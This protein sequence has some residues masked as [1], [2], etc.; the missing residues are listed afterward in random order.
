MVNR[1]STAKAMALDEE[2]GR[3]DGSK[4]VEVPDIYVYCLKFYLVL[5]SSPLLSLHST[6]LL[7]LHFSVSSVP[8]T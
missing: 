2:H 1:G 5:L 7:P 3:G 4:C 6:L 8:R